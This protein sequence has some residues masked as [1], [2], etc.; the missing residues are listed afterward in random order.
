M[1]APIT[2]RYGASRVTCAAIVPTGSNAVI[3]SISELCMT[4]P[5]IASAA[6]TSSGPTVSTEMNVVKR[7]ANVRCERTCQA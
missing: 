6:N 5:V 7:S 1:N 2:S 4:E 3:D